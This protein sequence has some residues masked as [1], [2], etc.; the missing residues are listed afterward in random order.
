MKKFWRG[1]HVT[2]AGEW[3]GA[4][5]LYAVVANYGEEPIMVGSSVVVDNTNELEDVCTDVFAIGDKVASTGTFT[6]I[7][8]G[9]EL[10]TNRVICRPDKLKSYSDKNI[11]YAYNVSKLRKANKCIGFVPGVE[12]EDKYGFRYITLQHPFEENKVLLVKKVDGHSIILDKNISNIDTL[13]TEYNLYDFKE[14]K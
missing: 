4:Y 11:R 14:A 2:K 1:A 8:V 13:V 10:D 7:V 9:H 6:G 12:Y 3:S 5:T